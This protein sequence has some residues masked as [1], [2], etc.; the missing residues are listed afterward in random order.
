MTEINI[1]ARL[2]ELVLNSESGFQ[3]GSEWNPCDFSDEEIKNHFD[4]FAGIS[5]SDGGLDVLTQDTIDVFYNLIA[6]FRNL[7]D[8]NKD[9]FA[10]SFTELSA[11]AI[12]TIKEKQSVEKKNARKQV[13]YFL[14]EFLKINEEVAKEENAEI[15]KLATQ[16]GTKVLSKGKG[17]TADQTYSWTDWRHSC[18]KLI[19]QAVCS[20]PSHLWNMGVVQENYLRGMWASALSMLVDKPKGM[21]GPGVLESTIR[22]LCVAII[23][24]CASLFGGGSGGSI[25]AL[26][27]ALL[28]AVIK[29]EHMANFVAEIC[30]KSKQTPLCREVLLAISHLHITSMSLGAKNIGSFIE[31]LARV[32]PVLMSSHLA[33]L[34]G[35]IDSPAHQIRSSLLQA[36]GLVV[37]SIHK[38]SQG[39]TGSTGDKGDT[40]NEDDDGDGGE[41]KNLN[42]D[43]EEDEDKDRES[44]KGDDVDENAEDKEEEKESDVVSDHN[45]A[46]LSRVRDS[47]LDLLTERT[48]DISY[49]TRAAVLKVTLIAFL[50]ASK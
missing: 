15:E 11:Q 27:S 46:Q 40:V 39:H 41:K 37:S 8:E 13:V 25:G 48:H 31:A 29:T 35:Q 33:T 18:L 36:M 34:K 22:G 5:S 16:K 24:R 21:G 28:D 44:N 7:S 6:N 42:A 14:V 3:I 38:A 23:T 10:Q 1:P 26:S 9:L 17:K 32:N 50:F 2:N 19:F 43:G 30:N 47:L 4:D 45:M 20:E 12:E 49:F